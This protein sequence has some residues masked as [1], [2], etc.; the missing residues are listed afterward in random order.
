MTTIADQIVRKRLETVRGVGAINLVGG[1]KREVEIRIR[2]AQLEALGIG[3][4]QVMNAI[5]NEN[6]ELPAGELRSSATETVVQIKGRVPT[7]EAFRQIIV[8][9]RAGQPV[10]LGEI[11][12]CATE[13]KSRKAWRCLTESARCSCRW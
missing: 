8:A 6:Q 13:S 2:P 12:T 10:T 3:V 9:R 5:H 7:P 1:T 11:A 4:D